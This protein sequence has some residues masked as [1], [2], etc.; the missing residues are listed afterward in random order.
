MGPTSVVL[1]QG[2]FKYLDEPPLFPVVRSNE[3]GDVTD[4]IEKGQNLLWFFVKETIPIGTN[5]LAYDDG[6]ECWLLA[7]LNDNSSIAVH[8]C[9]LKTVLTPPRTQLLSQKKPDLSHHLVESKLV[10]TFLC[11]FQRVK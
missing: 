1:S 3:D 10:S 6:V 4:R 8:Y 2:F 9:T 5:I 11:L 7:E